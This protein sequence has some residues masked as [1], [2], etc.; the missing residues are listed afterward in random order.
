MDPWSR[1]RGLAPS[2]EPSPAWG[3]WRL[4]S[5]RSQENFTLF[6]P[7]HIYREENTQYSELFP[8]DS[9]DIRER[10]PIS[11]NRARTLRYWLRLHLAPAKLIR[12]M[13]HIIPNS[14][15][16]RRGRSLFGTEFVARWLQR[17]LGS[18][19][20]RA[21][22]PVGSSGHLPWEIVRVDVDLQI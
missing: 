17:P 7:R 22:A 12:Q 20:R 18:S 16:R 9:R 8:L 13:S 1:I 11:T 21:P 4:W 6:P 3:S 10:E 15:D 2:P 19:A 5:Q 14:T